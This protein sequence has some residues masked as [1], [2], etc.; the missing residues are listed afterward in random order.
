[1]ATVTEY[2]K[3]IKSLET[4]VDA[5][6]AEN[7]RLTSRLQE[8]ERVPVAKAFPALP[9]EPLDAKSQG[10]LGFRHARDFL[11]HV[12]TAYIDHRLDK[13]LEPI[14]AN[15]IEKSF[16]DRGIVVKAVGSDEQAGIHDAYG[17]FLVPP[18]FSPELLKIDPETDPMAGKTR[19]VPMAAPVLGIPA[20]TDRNHTTSVAGGLTIR[21]RPET[22]ATNASRQEYEK[23]ELRATSLMG[24]GYATR[25][26]LEDSP[27]SVSAL[28]SSGF[29]DQFNYHIVKERLTGTGVGEYEGVLNSPALVSVAKETGQAADTIVF[30]NV[31]KMRA[32]CWGYDKAIW[33]ANHDCYPQLSQLKLDIGT[34]GQAMY[35]N[36]LVDGRPDQ[37]L[38]R[39]IIYSEYAKTIGDQGDLILGNWGEYLEGT[40]QPL[41]SEESIHVRFDT[42]EQ[43][44]KFWTRNDGRCWWRS[45]L[46]PVNSSQTLS[47]FVVLDAR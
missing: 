42:H 47:P 10:R 30:Q 26:I 1:M 6:E 25:E 21:R 13:R 28:I 9:A 29:T 37:L 15:Y 38:G 39:P 34:G 44:F 22:V 18:A 4:R 3:V 35:T 5:A 8:L 24:L 31:V 36:S 20:R 19:M 43:A 16:R 14:C 33:I 2:G 45:A 23:V 11:T 17:G 7:A 40:Y 32:R 41:R 12:M 46:T 27:I